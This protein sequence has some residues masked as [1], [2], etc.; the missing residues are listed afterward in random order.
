MLSPV[1]VAISLVDTAPSAGPLEDGDEMPVKVHLKDGEEVVAEHGED[2]G[3]IVGADEAADAETAHVV[4]LARVAGHDV[5]GLPLDG[6]QPAKQL[7][8]QEKNDV[9]VKM[10]AF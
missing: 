3:D 8:S 4:G 5:R 6:L 7:L 10:W 1:N 9:I 2:D